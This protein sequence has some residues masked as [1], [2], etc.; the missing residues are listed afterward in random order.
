MALR[1]QVGNRPVLDDDGFA[2]GV[3]K[4]ITEVEAT[5]ERQW[6]SVEWQFES[7]G[8]QKPYVLRL[9]TSLTLNPPDDKGEMNRLTLVCVRLEIIALDAL[10]RGEEPELDLENL[11]GLLVRYK[12][13][14]EKG[15]YR[16]DIPTLEPDTD[17]E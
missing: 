10:E 6:E 5:E 13:A 17:S 12:L 15:L 1:V 2:H 7:P 14:K 16:I 4:S 3:L 8:T 9:W 11:P